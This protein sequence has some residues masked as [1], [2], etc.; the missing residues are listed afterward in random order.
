MELKIKKGLNIPIDG[1]PKGEI[2][3]LLVEGR[4]LFPDQVALDLDPFD[5]YR[6][7]LLVKAGD[8]VKLGTPLVQDKHEERR[9]FVSP[10]S[11]TVQEIQR[12]I[13]RRLISIPIQLEGQDVH[14]FEP[15]GLENREQILNRLLEGGVFPHLKQRPFD[16]LADPKKE[17]RSIFVKALETAPFSVPAEWQVRGHEEDFATGLEALSKLTT[18]KVHLVYEEGSTFR[19]FTES[20]HVERSTIR[21]PHPAANPSV[22]IQFLDPIR[23]YTDVIWT[24]D[25]IG[26]LAIGHLLNR[27]VYFTPRVYSI[28]GPG[29]QAGKAIFVKGRAGFP[30]KA[31]ASGRLIDAPV[32]LISGNPLIGRKVEETDFMGFYETV[33][34]A[35]PEAV[36]Q[37]FLHF[38]RLGANKYSAS[39]AYLSG[40]KKGK[41]YFFTTSQH[42]EE[43]PF[44]IG[45]PYDKVMPLHLNTMLLVKAVMGEDYELAEKLGL[46]DVAPEDFALP[47]FVDPSK[48]DMMDIV[49]RGLNMYAR[50][51]LS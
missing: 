43:R 38:F 40:H 14:S 5:Q 12:G 16:L 37:E 20:K 15:I 39:G 8:Q 48:I 31:L 28:A 9:V 26:V 29:I 10:G 45:S 22:H 30:V 36:D 44:I 35:I 49:R 4:N 24:T 51:V 27:G 50:D 11:G 46:L 25:V 19:P 2:Q 13:K 34:S 21:G 17:P 6:F 42:G 23:K 41:D 47:T 32:R 1:Q 7:R 33:F 3:D 18:G